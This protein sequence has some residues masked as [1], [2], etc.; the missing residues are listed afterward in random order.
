MVTVM[1]VTRVV[2]MTMM[3]LRTPMRK[4]ASTDR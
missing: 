2:T 3:T 4:L 1:V